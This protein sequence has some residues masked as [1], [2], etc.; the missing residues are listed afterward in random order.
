M[1]QAVLPREN[2]L[3]V[4]CSLSPEDVLVHCLRLPTNY[5]IEPKIFAFE[6]GWSLLLFRI[7]LNIE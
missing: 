5:I 3:G 2:G 1:A 6:L 4:D 7:R